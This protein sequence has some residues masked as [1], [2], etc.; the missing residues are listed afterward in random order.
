VEVQVLGT[1]EA[2]DGSHRIALRPA[3][4]RLLAA[5]VA[6]RPSAVRYDALADAVWGEAVPPSATRS[7]QTHV[8]RLRSALGVDAVETASGGY[9]L[10]DAVEVDAGAFAEAVRIATTLDAADGLATLEAWDAA[11]GH[12]HGTPFDELGDWPPA[13]TERARLVELWHSALEQRC[14]VALTVGPA[15]DTVAE[16]E[17]MVLAEPLRERRWALLMTALAAGGRR[18]DALR[19]Y[20]RARRILANELG[21]SPGTELSRL[22]ASLLREDVADDVAPRAPHANL[23]AAIA[24]RIGRDEELTLVGGQVHDL[25]EDEPGPVV[26]L[27]RRLAVRPTVGVV[28][29]DAEV[30]AVLDAFKRAAAGEGPEVLLV[31]G[32]AGLGK[33]TVIAEAARVA[34]DGGACVLF[35]H[36]E[37][38]VA[39]PYQLFGEALGH[40]VAHTTQDELVAHVETW[41][42]ELARLVPAL[43]SR[44]P[45]LGPS[46]ATDADTERY[47]LFAAVVGLLAMTSRA[48]P[49]LLVLDDLQWADRAS[50]QLL[51][52]L[53]G[54][55]QAMRLLVLGTYRDAG[56]SQSHPLVETLADFHRH[57]GVARLELTGLDEAAVVSWMEAAAG[58]ALDDTAVR[59]ARTLHRE[60]DGN[61]FFVSEVLRHLA[62]TGAIYQDAAIGRWVAAATLNATELPASVRA[63]IGARVGR[64]GRDAE[65]VLS[66]ASVIGR[67]F[68]IELL[69]RA[70]ALPDDALLDTLDAATAAALVRELTDTPGHYSF[71]HALI[72]HTLYEELGPTRRARA[73]R[74]VAEALEDLCG[75]RP[76]SRIGELARHWFNAQPADLLKALDHSRRAG[77]AALAALAP[78][79]AL[80]YYTQALSLYA[81]SDDP[82]PTLG[83]DLS[84]GLGTAQRQTGDAKYRETLLAA[85]RRAAALGDTERLVTAALANN[86]GLFSAAGT[87]DTDRVELLEL[88]LDRLPAGH[89]LRALVLA[90]LCSELAYGRSLE[91]RHALAEEAVAIAR[92]TGDDAI[93][94]RVLN[95]IAF[96][97]S[98]PHLLDQSLARSGDALE[99]A[100]RV[101]DPVQLFWAAHNRAGHALRAGDIDEMKRC[102]DISWSIAERLDQPMM[103]WQSGM[104]RAMCAQLA[105]DTDDA[106]R[107]ATEALRIGLD[108]GQPDATVN[109]GAQLGQL[110]AQRGRARELVPLIEQLAAEVPESTEVITSARAAIYASVGRLE[111]A[112]QLLEESAAADFELLPDP[113]TWLTSMVSYAE[114][115]VAC[116][117]TTIAATLFDRLE[118][119]SDQVP[120]MFISAFPPVSHY[121]GDLATVLGRYDQADTY[122]ARAA[123]FNQRAGAKFVGATTDLAWGKMLAQR[124]APGDL[125]RARHLLTAAHAA[126]V[127]H[128]YA[129]IERAAAEALEHLHP[130]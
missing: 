111:D 129:G 89:P 13:I 16:A 107:W 93:I 28:G 113:G 36:C 81:R 55:D 67:D 61:P 14:A 47:Q 65:R 44:L 124:G 56:M 105:G 91:R 35:G 2:R 103:N 40:F 82:D 38:D 92:S 116:R 126:A 62:E 125:E 80:G 108:S 69:A 128:G 110:M 109:H 79:D 57:G 11:V 51:R 85:A 90:M 83:I 3:E 77:D 59:L 95:G 19:A 49:I 50:L 121:L 43:S 122:F 102:Y 58:H 30:A 94:V 97:L 54:T 10:A 75:D 106:E 114:V 76:R 87:V 21:I 32:E 52:H 15:A 29:R 68:D 17:A 34:F 88:A 18:P 42:S 63:V 70:T 78:G 127:A 37:E 7:L 104:M 74:Q 12:W 100:E 5:L 84:I 25:G 71:A 73:H 96:P 20:D 130:N 53:V 72:Q 22:H 112:H 41:G 60:T 98:L 66:V 101:G 120:T 115:C 64:L 86:R 39:A 48:H 4:R 117:D 31:S 24:T 99:V 46:T 119:F 123:Q 6:C 9:R 26:P 118:P 33:T 8:L 27:P 1:L 45:G 23:P